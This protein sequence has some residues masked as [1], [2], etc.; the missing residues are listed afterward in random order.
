MTTVI[1]KCPH[2]IHPDDTLNISEK[3][4]GTSFIS[5]NVL[6][7]VP[8]RNIIDKAFCWLSKYIKWIWEPDLE[9]RNLY[10]SRTTIKNLDN[11]NSGGYYDSDVW[12]YANELIKNFLKEGM[13]V[14]GEI[15]GYCPTGQAI[16][17]G[18]DYGCVP[19]TEGEP[20][21][22]EKHY[23]VRVYR[24]TTVGPDGKFYEFNPKEV[25]QWC[26][27]TGLTPVTTWYEGVARDL[28]PELEE[29]LNWPD[30]F[31]NKLSDDKRFYM[32]LNSPSCKNSVPHEGVVIK[33]FGK[34]SEA[35]KLKCFKFLDKEQKDQ[36][37]GI[38]NIEDEA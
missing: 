2:V 36:D 1:K 10:A 35:F 21:T 9:Y 26:S 13:T 16:Q 24:V 25:R 31:I 22:H 11:A 20:Y 15:V 33:I 7:K 14:Y 32:E 23:K 28:Y 30:E 27:D 8:P 19:P 18:Y 37:K 4:H 3:I 6:C 12:F 17:K 38:S 29:D 34:D 5:A